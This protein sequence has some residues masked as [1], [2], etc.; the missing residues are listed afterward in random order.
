MGY[1][2]EIS[3]EE[4]GQIVAIW[5][6]SEHAFIENILIYLVVYI[7][8]AAKFLKV[9]IIELESVDVHKKCFIFDARFYF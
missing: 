7:V 5:R 1:A 3:V 4:E 8:E 6:E 9:R 2:Q